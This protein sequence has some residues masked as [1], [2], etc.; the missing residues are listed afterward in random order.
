MSKY[1]KFIKE[2]GKGTICLNDYPMLIDLINHKFPELFKFKLEVGKW[3]K[4]RYG[5]IVCYQGESKGFGCTRSGRWC[6]NAVWGFNSDHY[7]WTQAT[8]K[9]VEEMLIKEAKKRGFVEGV[10]F[11]C[12]VSNRTKCELKTTVWQYFEERNLF[13]TNYS[14]YIFNNGKWA[15]IIEE[16][17]EL[18]VEEISKKY[19]REIKIVK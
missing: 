14:Q 15:T 16:P 19:G 1:K 5:S 12:V 18:T 2:L 9:E 3:Y 7:N 11:D 8:D 17:L 6:Y 10:M 4:N 13:S